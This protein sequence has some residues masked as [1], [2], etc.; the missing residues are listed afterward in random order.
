MKSTLRV[1]SR[2]YFQSLLHACA[3][4]TNKHMPCGKDFQAYPRPQ[5]ISSKRI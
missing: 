1:G 4:G 2:K 5:E 3:N